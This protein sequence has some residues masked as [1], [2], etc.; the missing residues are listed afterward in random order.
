MQLYQLMESGADDQAREAKA[1]AEQLQARLWRNQ[2]LQAEN[3]QLEAVF[4]QLSRLQ[5]ILSPQ[6][7][8]RCEH[9]RPSAFSKLPG[10]CMAGL[11]TVN[12]ALEDCLGQG[13]HPWE[14]AAATSLILLRGTVTFKK[15][16]PWLVSI[17]TNYLLKV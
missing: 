15:L 11:V 6:E 1:E 16:K 7:E 4:Q 17:G 9:G 14:A 10:R 12:S 3:R 8:S 5:N 2:Q 13:L